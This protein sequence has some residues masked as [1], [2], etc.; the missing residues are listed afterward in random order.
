M[1]VVDAFC[2]RAGVD[3]ALARF[4]VPSGPRQAVPHAAVAAMVVRNLVVS[5]V[6]LYAMGGWAAGEDPARLGLGPGWGGAM[7]DDRIGRALDALFDADGASIMTWVAARA[8]QRFSVAMDQL[9]NDSTSISMAGARRGVDGRAVRGKA[10]ARAARGHSKDHRPDL[11]Q[12]VAILTVSA[13]GAVPVAFRLADGNTNDDPTHTATWDSLASVL[14]PGFLYVADCKLASKANLAHIDSRGGRFVTVLPRTRGEDARLRDHMADHPGALDFA[15]A[16]ARPSRA[17]PGTKDLWHAAEGPFPTT[18]GHR[19]IVVLSERGAADAAA[20]RA[21]RIADAAARL[22]ALNARLAAP[23]PGRRPDP[24]QA[25]DSAITRANAA[26]W[27]RVDSITDTVV[28][29][30]RVQ[31]TRG[32]PGPNTSYRTIA[33]TRPQI[34]YT[35]DTALAQR[36]AASDGCYPLV[37]N[38][39][40]MVPGDVLLAYKGQPDIEKRHSQL[41]SAQRAAPLRLHDPGRIE[42]IATCHALALAVR[43]LIEREVR[44]SMARDRLEAL[45]L[46]PEHRLAR[47]P[48]TTHILNTLA[49]PAAQ[50]P[51]PV[52]ADLLHRL[53]M[54]PQAPHQ[55][56]HAA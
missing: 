44:L 33:T 7:D 28:S 27:V 36:D 34:R 50:P 42:A 5:P 38:D 6:P 10:T 30:R 39:P 15:Q 4:V 46:Y 9:H 23:G 14:G 55:H 3:E 17:E 16:I 20:S 31:T 48:T 1:A 26:R 41:K 12:V 47:A 40:D 52:Q 35:V 2:V 53:G 56:K 54:L 25:A 43:A 22:D 11:K 29:T 51:T 21:D 24:A 49:T 8:A 32:R 37:T 18:D 13:D 45:P 19:I